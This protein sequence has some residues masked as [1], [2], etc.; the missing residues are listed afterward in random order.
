MLHRLRKP[1]GDGLLDLPVNRSRAS[2]GAS[3]AVSAP[4]TFTDGES[5]MLIARRFGVDLATM[6]GKIQGM[7]R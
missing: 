1:L 4:S 3:N 7:W 6:P 5:V 2:N